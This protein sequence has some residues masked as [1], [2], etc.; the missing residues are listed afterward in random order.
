MKHR[1]QQLVRGIVAIISAEAAW[2]L[3]DIAGNWSDKSR[4]FAQFLC[5]F[6]CAIAIYWI[7][8]AVVDFTAIAF[9][10]RREQAR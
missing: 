10:R 3:F 4:S 7:L 6:L 8:S 9:A 1:S 2:W 5:F